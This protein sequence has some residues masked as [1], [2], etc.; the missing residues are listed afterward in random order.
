[1]N[2]VLQYKVNFR[3]NTTNVWVS[4]GHT[5]FQLLA[6]FGLCSICSQN[7]DG[8]SLARVCQLFAIARMLRFSLKFA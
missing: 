8:C 4:N 5:N 2:L 7:L 3:I 6:K 1:M